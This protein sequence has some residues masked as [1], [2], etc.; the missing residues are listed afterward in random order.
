MEDIFPT[1][2][3][4]E[5]VWGWFKHITFTVHLVSVIIS[6]PTQII[7][8]QIPEARDRHSRSSRLRV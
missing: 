6:A 5:E 3:G 7:R 1:D 4:G 8:H 2:R